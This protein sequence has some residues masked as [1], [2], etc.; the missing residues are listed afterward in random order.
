MN[1]LNVEFFELFRYLYVRLYFV[2]DFILEG[3]RFFGIDRRV[4]GVGG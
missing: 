4:E 1:F 3:G 2:V